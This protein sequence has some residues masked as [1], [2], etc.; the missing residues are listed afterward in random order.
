MTSLLP[1]KRAN[2]LHPRFTQQERDQLAVVHGLTPP[3]LMWLERHLGVILD[4][5]GPHNR[6][7][8]VRD[9]LQRLHSDMEVVAARLKRW[10]GATRPAP[11]AE[12][13]GH[14]NIAG[15][16]FAAKHEAPDDGTWPEQLV[17]SELAL[18]LSGAIKLAVGN[19][20]EKKRWQHPASPA[21]IAKILER[22]N[23]PSDAASR[24]AAIALVPSRT[25]EG[26]SDGPSFRGV[27]DIVFAACFRA[28]NQHRGSPDARV[29]T[30]SSSIRT[31][32]ESLPASARRRPGRPRK[33]P[34]PRG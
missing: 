32:L 6:M 22:L 17:A 9:E 5:L 20:P 27:A 10:A 30:A 15:A 28:L 18:L 26:K 1:S 2:A 7:G 8:D 19:A 13:I 34:P 24:A 16:E 31:Y 4:C 29:P 25:A 3:Q 11:G 23:R 21:A 12:A 33:Q 14:L